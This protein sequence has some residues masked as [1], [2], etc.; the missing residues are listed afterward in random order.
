LRGDFDAAERLLGDAIK[1]AREDDRALALLQAELAETQSQAYFYRNRG[2]EAALRAAAEAQE[3]ALRAGDRGAQAKAIQAEGMVRYGRLLW[4]S[5]KDFSEPRG[6]FERSLALRQALGD[7]SAVAHSTF[8]I[9]LTYEQEGKGDRA[10]AL[11]EQALSL[12]ERVNDK[13]TMAYA[14][15]HLAGFHE[16]G[17]DLDRALDFHR[18][19]LSLREEI[20]AIRL[21]PYALLAVGELEVKKGEYARARATYERALSTA[22]QTKSASALLWSHQGLGALDE[23]EGLRESALSHYQRALASAEEI[24]HLE[25]IAAAAGAAS[26]V[27]QALG[28]TKRSRELAEQAERARAKAGGEPR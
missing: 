3:T 21:M 14:L 24:A 27:H 5:S 20:G 17:G 1:R 23:R 25:G 8:H 9:G 2:D 7:L 16:E 11:Y 19:C 18:R 15:R 4:Q 26:K 22:E 28:D 13:S 12:A 10:R 6:V